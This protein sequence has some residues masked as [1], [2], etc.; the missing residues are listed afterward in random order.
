MT[1]PL[2]LASVHSG[3]PA[4]PWD[5]RA[6]FAPD[7][8]PPSHQLGARRPCRWIKDRGRC[9]RSGPP[10]NPGGERCARRHL[11]WWSGL[12][13]A[14]AR[15]GSRRLALEWPE[16]DF[17]QAQRAALRDH[18][19]RAA[20]GRHPLD[21]RSL[22][23]AGGR[24][25]TARQGAG[26]RPG[27]R[28]RCPR[29][30]AAHPD[31]ARDR[32]RRDRQRAGRGHLLPVVQHGRRVRPAPGDRVLEFGTTGKLRNSDLVMYDRT[33]ESWWQQ[34]PGE[35]IVGELT[36]TQLKMLPARLESFVRSRTGARRPGSGPDR[37]TCAVTAPIRMSVTTAR[38]RPFLYHGPLP[39]RDRAACPRGPGRNEA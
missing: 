25:G 28:R 29:L 16:T 4:A 9:S 19:G 39:E 8:G 32:Q 1:W 37:A 2:L 17:D 15:G 33:T 31:L 20:Q 5:A 38:P 10:G 13:G 21:R 6:R 18:L 23:S 24:G 11:R 27:G 26:D 3:T 36:G 30:P 14:A 7:I 35:A 34:F 22:S 12:L